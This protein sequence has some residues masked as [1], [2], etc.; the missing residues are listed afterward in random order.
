MTILQQVYKAP[1]SL[2]RDVFGRPL[3]S[4]HGSLVEARRLLRCRWPCIVGSRVRDRL[5]LGSTRE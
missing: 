2:A 4:E 1:P 3:R 5:D